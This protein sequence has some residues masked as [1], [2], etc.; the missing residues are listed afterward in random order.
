MVLYCRSR[1]EIAIA[2][3]GIVEVGTMIVNV[4][5][6]YVEGELRY[7][8]DHSDMVALVHER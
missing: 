7:L 4:D 2:M 8:F 5:V 6:R 1:I 3:F